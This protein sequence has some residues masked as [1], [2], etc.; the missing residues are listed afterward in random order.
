V[1]GNGLDA[2]DTVSTLLTELGDALS[3]YP[4]P[5]DDTYQRAEFNKMFVENDGSQGLHNYPY[6]YQ[7]LQD[8]ITS[9]TE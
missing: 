1:L 5:G 4:N 2:Q 3:N 6:A 8:A 9:L 7:L